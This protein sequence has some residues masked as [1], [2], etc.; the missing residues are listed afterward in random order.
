MKEKNIGSVGVEYEG[1]QENELIW[2]K[3][4]GAAW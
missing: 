1:C 3:Y 2:V 4:F